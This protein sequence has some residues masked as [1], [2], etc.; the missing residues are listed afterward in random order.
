M[1][2]GRITRLGWIAIGLAVLAGL[3]ALFNEATGYRESGV[4]DW[5]HVALAFS[6]PL[7]M[8]GLFKGAAK[9]QV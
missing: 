6:V 3:L 1:A 5:G 7:L 4:V 2:N 8:Y 9:R